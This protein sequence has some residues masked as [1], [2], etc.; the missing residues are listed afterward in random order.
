VDG[1]PPRVLRTRKEGEPFGHADP[2]LAPLVAQELFVYPNQ[3]QSQDQM[4]RDKFDCYNWAKQQSGFEPMQPPAATTPPH[5][6]RLPFHF[7]SSYGLEAVYSASLKPS[8]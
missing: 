8:G 6:V 3:G 1:R 4:G 5:P 7:E 2:R